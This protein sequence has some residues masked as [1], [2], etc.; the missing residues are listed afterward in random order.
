MAQYNAGTARQPVLR[1]QLISTSFYALNNSNSKS[2]AIGMDIIDSKFD[3]VIKFI[4]N[5]QSDFT[6]R[7]QTWEKLGEYFDQIEAYLTNRPYTMAQRVRVDDVI[8]ALTT[9]Y[10]EPSLLIEK[11]QIS[12]G[13]ITLAAPL[14]PLDA[15][16]H[17]AQAAGPLAS[18]LFK[19]VAGKSHN[20]PYIPGVILQLVS[21]EG[22]KKAK[23][24][25]DLRLGQ[26][27]ENQFA[28]QIVLTTLVSELQQ[29][30][31]SLNCECLLCDFLLQ[32]RK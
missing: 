15:T 21:F 2:I 22:L 31:A 4:S 7:H 1:K 8:I 9:S 28:M 30:L 16:T 20:K 12:A 14:E 29:R 26:L 3:P 17:P 18:Y 23:V 6:I 19:A 24:C 11:A 27:K 10:S 5:K 32:K 25:V 13:E